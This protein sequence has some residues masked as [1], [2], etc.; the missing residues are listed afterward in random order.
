MNHIFHLK[1]A[2]NN[3]RH[4]CHVLP[5]QITHGQ[6][7]LYT[8]GELRRLAK[9]YCLIAKFSGAGHRVRCNEWCTP[10]MGANSWG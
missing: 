5:L 9:A 3:P 2:I 10:S 1:D 6:G 4:D 8:G 7:L